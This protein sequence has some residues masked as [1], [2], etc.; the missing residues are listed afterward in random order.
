M[1]ARSRAAARRNDLDADRRQ[2]PSRG[3]EGA[4][5]RLLKPAQLRNARTPAQ[6]R[7]DYRRKSCVLRPPAESALPSTQ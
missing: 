1:E 5:A 2:P 6:P 3:E 7:W 4:E